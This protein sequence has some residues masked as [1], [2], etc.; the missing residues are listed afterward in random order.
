M[1]YVISIEASH[2]RGMGHCFRGLHLATALRRKGDDVIFIINNDELSKEILRQDGFSVEVRP[3]YSDTM[4]WEN[5][6]IRMYHPDWW[7]NDRLA[8]TAKH[9]QKIVAAGINLATFDDHGEGAK[10]A[11]F[12]FLAMDPCPS[13]MN[14][15]A[16]YGAKYMILN[17]E[18]EK[19]RNRI[20]DFGGRHT[21]FVTLGGSDTYGLTPKVVSSLKRASNDLNISVAVGPNFRTHA[22]LDFAVTGMPS[23]LRIHRSVSDLICLMAATDIIICGGGVTLFEAAALGIPALTIANEAHEIHIAQWF[24]RN[25]FG[26]YNGFR[27]DYSESRLLTKLTELIASK[28]ML[29]DMKRIGKHLVDLGGLQRIVNKIKDIDCE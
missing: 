23:S 4:D 28:E 17:P 15:N 8:T 29:C 10:Y 20:E 11:R 9:A 6:V 26:F 7:I 21:I 5:E 13:E 14:A 1:R 3:S 19:Y 18:I 12:N 24:E 2:E 25:G 22:E 16:L 27:T